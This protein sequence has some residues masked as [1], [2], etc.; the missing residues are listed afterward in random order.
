MKWE[1]KENYVTLFSL[2]K[3]KKKPL[4]IFNLL[5]SMQIT[6]KSV[7]RTITQYNETYFFYDKPRSERPDET[8]IL[9][10][11][12]D[13]AGRI[14]RKAQLKQKIH[15]TGNENFPTNDV[16]HHFWSTWHRLTEALW[17]IRTTRYKKLLG[18][19]VNVK[20]RQILFMDEKIFIVE[21]K[22]DRQNDCVY[23]H[24]S[25][26]VAANCQVS[27]IKRGRYPVSVIVWWEC[28]RM[29]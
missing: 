24:R 6:C 10:A 7:Y 12:K 21:S 26:E 25:R 29:A 18:K 27:K 5:R 15:C 22:L 13:V 9:E 19:R 4:E 14:Y 23:D 2:Q 3:C 17:Q 20:Q 8:R 28:N 11:V 16:P 1:V